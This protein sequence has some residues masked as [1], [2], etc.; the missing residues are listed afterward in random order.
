MELHPRNVTE[1]RPENDYRNLWEKLF[2]VITKRKSLA[3]AAPKRA[4][5]KQIPALQA[6]RQSL[7]FAPLPGKSRQR[8][9]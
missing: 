9:A 8:K 6:P 4:R 3:P 2:C 1:Q 5:E 7:V